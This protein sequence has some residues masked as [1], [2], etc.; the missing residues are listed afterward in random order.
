MAGGSRT[1]SIPIKQPAAAEK[2]P[3]ASKTPPG[4]FTSEDGKKAEGGKPATDNDKTKPADGSLIATNNANIA[5]PVTPQQPGDN[6]KTAIDTSTS[7]ITGQLTRSLRL[8]PVVQDPGFKRFAAAMR[9]S[10]S[11]NDYKAK[12]RGGYLG[13]YQF[14]REALIEVG[15]KNQKGEWTGINGAASEA[16]FLNRPS[17]QDQAFDIWMTGLDRQVNNEGLYRH[18]GKNIKDKPADRFGILAGAHLGG[19]AGLY[20]YLEKNKHAEDANGTDIGSYIKKFSGLS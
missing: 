6:A 5:Q 16:A 4:K 10:E 15:Y 17:I 19:V 2:K 1:P 3:E 14:G 9:E 8:K 20:D 12:N 7:G 13:A 11:T 18:I